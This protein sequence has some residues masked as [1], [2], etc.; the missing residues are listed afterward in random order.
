MLRLDNAKPIRRSSIVP[1]EL[2]NVPVQCGVNRLDST[3]VGAA[4][5]AAVMV[6]KP[7]SIPSIL[8]GKM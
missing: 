4:P 6:E 7:L 5:A 1:G 2:E 8:D 3:E